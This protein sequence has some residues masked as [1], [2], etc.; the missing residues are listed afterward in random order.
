MTTTAKRKL[1]F[2]EFK[3]SMEPPKVRQ[4]IEAIKELTVGNGRKMESSLPKLE[5]H[6]GSISKLIIQYDMCKIKPLFDAIL[7]HCGV[8]VREIEFI[9]GYGHDD[10]KTE[11]KSVLNDWRIFLRGFETRFPN[12]NYLKIEYSRKAEPAD[13][14]HWDEILKKFSSLTC[15]VIKTCPKFPIEKFFSLNGQLE[16]VTLA[17]SN[18]WRIDQN[19]LKSM[20]KLLPNLIYLKMNFVNA[21]QSNYAQPFG[22]TYFRRLVTLKVGSRNKTYSNVIRFLSA[23][24]HALE[25]IDLNISGELDEKALKMLSSYKELKRLGLGAYVTN[26]QLESVAKSL[27]QIESLAVN[28]Q[29]RRLTG[30]GVVHLMNECKQL[31]RIVI[32]SGFK[33]YDED[34]E[35]LCSPIKKKIKND[36]W[37]IDID[38]GTITITKKS[39]KK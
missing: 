26:K 18:E 17:N 3:D 10:Q 27:P 20:D 13:L 32:Y 5:I 15:L 8:N 28:F 35:K 37:K 6:G 4:K 14:K 22:L 19:L 31:K 21:H 38:G 34:I 39:P 24:G 2:E 36:E 23:S 7:K 11:Y 33:I 29:K 25:E 12:L 1:D 30:M 16:R 9:R